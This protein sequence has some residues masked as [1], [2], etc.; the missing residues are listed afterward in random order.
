MIRRLLSLFTRRG[1]VAGPDLAASLSRVDV[2]LDKDYPFAPRV[3]SFR[4]THVGGAVV[5]RY[6]VTTRRGE[7][8]VATDSAVEAEE[9]RARLG[10][11]VIDTQ[12]PERAS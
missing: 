8:A 12:E 7:L 9:Y 6:H 1:W 11:E 10:G 5:S 2:Q 3:G 4:R